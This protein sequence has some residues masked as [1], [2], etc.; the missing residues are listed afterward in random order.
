M[1]LGAGIND[2]GSGTSA[3][4][5]ILDGIKRYKTNQKVRFLW[6]GAEES[7]TLGSNHY[8]ETLSAAEVAKIALYLNFGTT[9]P[10]PPSTSPNID[11]RRHDCKPRR[12]LRRL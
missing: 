11:I 3:L 4:L 1:Q 8:T 7:G 6:F 9:P 10:L 12:L 5:E 2:D